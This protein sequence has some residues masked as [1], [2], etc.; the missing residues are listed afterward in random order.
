M[1][2]EE[3]RRT[4]I[5]VLWR[6]LPGQPFNWGTTASVIGRPPRQATSLDVPEDWVAPM[7]RRLIEPFAEA[8]T[9]P[10][11]GSQ[12][13]II[14]AREFELLK[15][16]DG[17]AERFPNT[18]LCGTCQTFRSV[19]P[20]DPPPACAAHGTMRQL[21]YVEVHNCGHL[22]ALRPPRCEHGCGA[23]MRL[24]NTDRMQIRSWFWQCSRCRSRSGAPLTRWCPT[25]GLGHVQIIRVPQSSAYYAQQI[26]V[27]NPPTRT[28]YGAVSHDSVYA[29]SIAQAL[30]ILPPGLD[31]LSAAGRAPQDN[32]GTFRQMVATLRLSEDDPMYAELRQRL[33]TTRGPDWREEV[34]SL[35]LGPA[36]LSALGEECRQLSLALDAGQMSVDDLLATTADDSLTTQYEGYRALFERHHIADITLLRELPVAFVVAGFTRSSDRAVTQTSRGDQIATTFRFFQPSQS[37]RFPMYGLRTLT[38]GLLVRLDPLRIVDWLVASGIIADPEL[39]DADAA[40]RWLFQTMDPVTSVFDAPENQVSKAVLSLTHSVSHRFM[41]S[42]AARCGLNVDSLAEYLFASNTAFLIYANTRSEFILGGLEHVFRYDLADAM[43]E[44]AAET[45]CVFDPPCREAGG[46]ACA[47]C[48][49]VFEAACSRFNTVLDRNTLFGSIPRP[50][51]AEVPDEINWEPFWPR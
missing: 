42:L 49:F 13:A 38:E 15:A 46:G 1:T 37:A 7:L 41:K 28:Q 27:L 51:G 20:I 3:F 29:A 12:L 5:Q 34:D 18:Y 25:C 16:H 31:E 32:D 17:Q 33:A 40:R 22:A 36:R 35:Q 21:S 4:N 44:L 10:G 26:T 14:D 24:C 47:A 23:A 11:A 8:S 50:A 43:A 48:L 39:K 6:H 45:R 19:R 30:G 9:V 2:T